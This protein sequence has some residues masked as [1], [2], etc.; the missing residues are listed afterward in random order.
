MNSTRL[1]RAIVMM[2]AVAVVVGSVFISG[3]QQEP[4]PAAMTVEDQQV[5]TVPPEVEEQLALFERIASEPDRGESYWIGQ[6]DGQ[7]VELPAG[8]VNGLAAALAAAGN[9]GVVLVRSGMHTESGMV[10]VSQKVRIIGQ[11]GAIMV[12]DTDPDPNDIDLNPALRVLNANHVTIWGLEIRPQGAAG[13]TAVLLEGAHHALVANNTFRDHQNGVF[14]EHADHSMI[15]GNT[16]ICAPSTAGP[17]GVVN[18]N[19]KHVTVASND[20]TNGLF[21]VWACDE[22]GFLLNNNT[23]GNFIGIILCKVPAGG[24]RL[25][26]GQLIGSDESGARWLATGN[27]SN[28]NQWGYL[29][30]DSA[31]RNLLLNNGASGNAVYDVELTADTYRFGFLTPASYNNRFVAGSYPNI[32]VKNCGNNNTIIGGQLVNNNNDP[33]F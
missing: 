8:S 2:I 7:V 13:G 30:I 22:R 17:M 9:N 25:P 12:F 20:I 4:P 14:V 15:W 3:C 21:G 16:I 23:H 24:Y 10:T 26:G 19:G 1:P 6:L 27:Q 32:V 11:A 33:C 18:C 31:N 29:V 28:G 5:L